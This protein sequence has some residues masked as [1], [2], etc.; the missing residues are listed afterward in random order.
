MGFSNHQTF[1]DREK[2]SD[3]FPL[4]G[5]EL[6]QR[7]LGFHLLLVRVEDLE[8]SGQHGRRQTVSF[9][10]CSSRSLPLCAVSCQD[11]LPHGYDPVALNLLV[12]SR[13]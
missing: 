12:D 11:H 2:L 10:G 1:H 5:Q 13:E 4:H 6:I 3:V 9:L 7:R 8:L